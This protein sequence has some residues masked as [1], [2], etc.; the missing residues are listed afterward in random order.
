MTHASHDWSRPWFR[1]QL[2]QG[3]LL[4]G[5]AASST[6]ASLATAGRLPGT[7]LPQHALFLQ[8]MLAGDTSIYEVSWSAPYTL[9]FWLA[10]PLAH[11]LGPA[12]SIWTTRASSTR[13]SSR[14]SRCG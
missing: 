7:D 5:L 10:M 3:W 14:R 12:K 6:F 2:V 9:L 8:R 1:S 11:W 13:Y 4:V